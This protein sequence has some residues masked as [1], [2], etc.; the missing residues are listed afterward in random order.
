MSKL[1]LIRTYQASKQTSSC[2]NAK[3]TP[4]TQGTKCSKSYNKSSR[5]YWTF[6]YEA[7]GDTIVVEVLDQYTGKFRVID[8]IDGADDHDKPGYTPHSFLNRVKERK[9]RVIS[10][11]NMHIVLYKD[12]DGAKRKDIEKFIVSLINHVKNIMFTTIMSDDE[13]FDFV[14]DN[15]P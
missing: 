15:R 12:F 2:N 5:E 8:H 10:N 3:S 4:A 1:T 11:V 6:S 9:G 14:N 7:A 13:Y